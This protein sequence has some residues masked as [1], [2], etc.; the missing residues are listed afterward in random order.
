[1]RTLK[2]QRLKRSD[3]VAV[4]SPS[5]G[6]PYQFPH[7]YQHGLKQL[8][9]RFGLLVKEMPTAMLAPDALYKDP[10]QRAEDIN[11]AFA[12]PNVQAIIVSIGGD[13]SVRILEYLDLDLILSHPKIIMGYSDATTFLTYL[14]Q[15]GLVTF[16]GPAIM[17]GFSQLESL[18]NR[19]TEHIRTIL[20]DTFETYTYQAYGVYTERYQDFSDPTN[21]GK[22]ETLKD[23]KIG[24]QWL[25]GTG[26]TNGYLFGGCIEVLEFLK[27]T[28]YWPAPDFWNDKILFFETS[29]EVPSV[30]SV[31]YFLRNYGTQGIL[32][33]VRG[34]L[35]GR[36]RDYTDEDKTELIE[37]IRAMLTIEFDCS[38][39]PVV[40]NLDFGHTDP[41]WIMPNGILCEIDC[42]TQTI[43][44]LEC[45]TS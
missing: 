33:R 24:Q 12:D 40:A 3:T 35:F 22:V 23:E 31:K 29:E 21:V 42:E 13:D 39:L 11:R 38:E 7:V 37:M 8:Q 16:N 32:Q 25:Q 30:S 4:L 20:M 5:A 18:P 45:P 2:P 1:M 26:K 17:A 10:K 43:R 44:L 15:Q 41:Q 28:R 19:F 6:L 36:A 34:I 9:E 27:G 14:N